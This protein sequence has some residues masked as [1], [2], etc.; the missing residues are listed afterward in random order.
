MI[1]DESTAAAAL[2]TGTVDVFV[3]IKAQ[4]VASLDQT[5]PE[6]N[7]I[8]YLGNVHGVRFNTSNPPLDQ[9]EVRRALH[10][11]TD[12]EAVNRMQMNPDTLH[13]RYPMG[14]AWPGW[15]AMEDMPESAQ[16]LYDYN[17]DLAR[18]MLDDAGLPA[19]FKLTA[20]GRSDGSDIAELLMSQWADLGIELTFD[21]IDSAAY[22]ATYY[23][24]NT[25]TGTPL[26]HDMIIGGTVIHTPVF[27]AYR[28]FH[29]D[30]PRNCGYYSHP[31]VDEKL[32]AASKEED[33]EKLRLMME[34]AF[35]Q[36]VED[37]SNIPF[38]NTPQYH[39]W[40]PWVKNC[41][42]E[43]WYYHRSADVH[44]WWLD[45][46]LKESMGY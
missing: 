33:P 11:G 31:M 12:R 32:D 39:Y 40:W 22:S 1:L 20:V 18:Q 45:E 42:G 38:A 30:G 28:Y 41:F 10:I 3:K 15:V 19:T 46:E 21:I 2:R 26:T 14:D 44:N 7:K 25:E 24:G 36:I 43:A 4:H 23:R 9:K 34:E 29:S 5:N 13:H 27:F 35:V 8:V 6:L 16:M 37:A 17:P